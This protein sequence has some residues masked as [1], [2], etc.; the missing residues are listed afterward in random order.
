MTKT[1]E[2]FSYTHS[3]KDNESEQAKQR[4]VTE[5]VKSFK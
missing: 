4:G 2:W 1:K 5:G 3:K